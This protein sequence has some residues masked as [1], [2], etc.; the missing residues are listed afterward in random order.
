MAAV[1]VSSSEALCP[2]TPTL[3]PPRAER[4]KTSGDGLYT[5]AWPASPKSMNAAGTAAVSHTPFS[6]T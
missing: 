5:A 6:D 2:L 1:P 4:E 3:S